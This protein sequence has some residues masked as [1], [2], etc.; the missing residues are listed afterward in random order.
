MSEK[1][2]F[3]VCNF[4]NAFFCPCSFHNLGKIQQLGA[5]NTCFNM[6]E[7]VYQNGWIDT[8][9]ELYVLVFAFSVSA[10][11]PHYF[12]KLYTFF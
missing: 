5:H 10:E 7:E 9:R 4:P 1:I 11:H 2:S 12:I 3:S 8:V 6:E